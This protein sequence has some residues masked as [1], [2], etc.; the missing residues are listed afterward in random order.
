MNG[1]LEGLLAAAVAG[2]MQAL[3]LWRADLTAWCD[4]A[5]ARAALERI[6]YLVVADTDQR[7]V[8]QYASVIVPIGTHAEGDG[9]FTNQGR[10][11]QRFNQAIT[12][13]GESRAGWHVLS[14]LLSRVTA[15]RQPASAAEVFDA[16][17]G[18]SP[19]F[20]GLSYGR[21]GGQGLPAVESS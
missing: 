16:L 19:A 13:A 10:R 5:Q 6:P 2:T 14:D 20:R 9:T 17:S 11:V 15:G 18:E 21:L 4:P 7:E 1:A 3:V 12:P 8:A